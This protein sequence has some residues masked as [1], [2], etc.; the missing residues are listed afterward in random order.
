MDERSCYHTCPLCESKLAIKSTRHGIVYSCPACRGAMAN[1][2]VLRGRVGHGPV[3]NFWQAAN[4]HGKT[5]QK[6]C[7]FCRQPMTKFTTDP[8]SCTLTLDICKQCRLIWFDEDGLN[9]THCASS[10]V[11]NDN[12]QQVSFGVQELDTKPYGLVREKDF[13]AIIAEGLT[14]CFT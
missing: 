8:D 12:I 10:A 2:T 5:S 13:A 3:N 9:D 11:T 1:L 7:P 6:G 4:L 14:G